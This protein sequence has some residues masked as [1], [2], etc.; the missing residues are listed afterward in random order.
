MYRVRLSKGTSGK[1]LAT[2]DAGVVMFMTD[3][4]M[5]MLHGLCASNWNKCI[6]N[7]ILLNTFD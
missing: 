7:L 5:L 3:G 6:D 4:K 1:C 2:H